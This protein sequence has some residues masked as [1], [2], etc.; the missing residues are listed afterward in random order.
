LSRKLFC[1]STYVTVLGVSGKADEH[2]SP[3]MSTETHPI[4]TSTESQAAAVATTRSNETHTGTNG[5]T[6]SN[7][8]HTGTNGTTGSNETH[9]QTNGTTGSN[10]THT[11]TNGTTGSNETHT[12]TNGTTGSNETHT[13]TNGTTGS[14]E[15]GTVSNST[16]SSNANQTAGAA[17]HGSPVEPPPMLSIFL[18]NDLQ[19]DIFPVHLENGSMCDKDPGNY[20]STGFD[21]QMTMR[22]EV[23]SL[24]S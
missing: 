13:Q 18:V 8:T 11:V 2:N 9:T 22:I 7:E 21:V 4:Q 3:P 24:G 6:G 23:W 15:T 5:T 14:N 20:P 12:V 16:Q 19:Y 1:E 17:A 10:E